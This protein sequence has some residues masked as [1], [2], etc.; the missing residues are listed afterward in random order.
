[1]TKILISQTLVPG[2]FV[3]DQSGRAT[4][5]RAVPDLMGSWFRYDPKLVGKHRWSQRLAIRWPC[6][7][8][9]S[10]VGQ[11]QRLLWL[12]ARPPSC[13]VNPIEPGLAASCMTRPKLFAGRGQKSA[14]L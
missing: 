4:R 6:R 12:A 10:R 13:R 2:G 9:G 7:T 11:G 8:L 14:R 3:P 5:D 1:M